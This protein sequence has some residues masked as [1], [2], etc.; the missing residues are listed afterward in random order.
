MLTLHID[1]NA[2]DCDKFGRELFRLLKPVY[3][4]MDIHEFGDAMYLLWE[5]L[6]GNLQNKEPFWTLSYADDPL[7]WGDV[8]QTRKQYEEMLAY[9][10]DVVQ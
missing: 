5:G 8:E 7:S 10:D 4:K 2:L 6:A 3:E 9:Y 1:Y